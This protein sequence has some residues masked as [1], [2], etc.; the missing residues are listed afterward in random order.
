MLLGKYYKFIEN[1]PLIKETVDCIH[2]K[3]NKVSEKIT[4]K[5][6]GFQFLLVSIAES[7][8]FLLPYLSVS[9][10]PYCFIPYNGPFLLKLSGSKEM[11]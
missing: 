4:F 6:E 11:Q 10:L 7:I 1:N 9:K 3:L 2:V 5:R 8:C